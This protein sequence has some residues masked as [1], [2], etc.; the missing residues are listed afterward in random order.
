MNSVDRQNLRQLIRELLSEEIAGLKNGSGT[1]AKTTPVPQVR[2]EVVVVRSDADLMAFVHRL[3]DITKV[4]HAR[5][6][7][8]SERW[9]FRLAGG[10]SGKGI[11]PGA[12]LRSKHSV[13]TRNEPVHFDSGLVSERQIDAIPAGSDR[14]ILGKRAMLTPL[15]RDR[16]R[17]KNICI[18]RA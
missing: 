18:E 6:E 8:E 12:S 7:I 11:S 1:F 15:A 14:L 4:G 10:R 13:N 2:E 9:V 17:Q 5:R 3:L 16:I